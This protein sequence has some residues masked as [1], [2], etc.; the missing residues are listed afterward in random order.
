MLNVVTLTYNR[1]IDH[2]NLERQRRVW[3]ISARSLGRA[4]RVDSA[5]KLRIPGPAGDIELMVY[6]P[7]GAADMA[8]AFLWIHG[9]GFLLGDL[10][11]AD[12]IC[13]HLA[14]RSG[15]VVVAVRYRLAPEH[16]LYAGREDCLAA[17][18]WLAESGHTIGIDGSRLAIGGDSAGG[19]LTAAVT[20]RYCERGGKALK[21]QVLVY[22]ATNLRDDFDSMT[23]NADGYL[24]TR[25]GIKA[26][27]AILAER[28][29]DL[30][31]PWLS[32]ALTRDLSKLPGAV[33][34]LAGY[35]P[36]RDDGLAYAERLR[37]AGLP[38]DLLHYAGQFHG[39]V[40]FNGVLRAARDALDRIGDALGRAFE[41]KATA[42]AP[43]AATVIDRTTEIWADASRPS[44][45]L[46]ARISRDLFLIGFMVGER[47]EHL[48]GNLFQRILPGMSRATRAMPQPVAD[49]RAFVAGH[50]APLQIHETWRRDWDSASAPLR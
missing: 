26:M 46:G 21:L 44:P 39:F 9:G 42:P 23:E 13:R 20:Q 43:D 31:D 27:K 35:D 4:G 40:N 5:R 10:S 7:A 36:I 16:D 48:G 24:L 37:E 25:G 19:N 18:E 28:S 22:P 17:L 41:T 6:R 34:L 14:H 2:R 33:V 1:T 12:A 30:A 32:P 15:A 50:F 11:T 8:P 38:V 47:L 49:L 29:P 3:R 45:L